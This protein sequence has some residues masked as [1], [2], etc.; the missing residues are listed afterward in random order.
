MASVIRQLFDLD[1]GRPNPRSKQAERQQAGG[2]GLPPYPDGDDQ[3]PE[4]YGTYARA[5]WDEQ[6][7]P[8]EPLHRTWIRNILMLLGFQ[9][10]EWDRVTG[11]F[12][13][14]PVPSYRERP[15]TNLMLP[16]FK[17]LL[18]K[19]TKNRPATQCVAASNEPK[20]QN[21]A[22]LGNDAL[23]GKWRELK[24]GKSLRRLLAWCIPTGTAYWYP[25]WNTETGNLVPLTLHVEAQKID[26]ETGQPVGAEVIE[27][28]CDENGEPK[29]TPD[30]RYDLE[31]Q[32]HYVD[33]GDV[34]T[35]VL[36][37]FQV[38]VNPGA[39]TEEDVSVVLV[40][41][42]LP[43]R[44]IRQRWP[45]LDNV[46]AED[47][48]I[49]EL[50]DS[51]TS[52]NITGHDP[53]NPQPGGAADRDSMLPKALVLR[54][55]E[56]QRPEYPEGRYWVTV[57]NQLAEKPG[58]LPNGWPVV[59][60]L[61]EVEI[62]G[63][64]HGG[65]T[66]E[67]AVQIQ[68][69]YN[70]VNGLIKEHHNLMLRGKWLV[71]I[72]SNIRR[73]Q[74]T[75]MAGEVI[76][77]TPG[78][79]PQMATLKPL[80]DRVYVERERLLQDFETITGIHRASMGQAPPGVSAG[81]AF[82]ILQEA[83]DTDLGP[84]LA[85]V[86]EAVAQ[87]GWHFIQ[88]MQRHYDTQRLVH[89]VGP[90]RHYQARAFQGSDLTGVVDVV[91]EAGSAFPWSQAARQNLLLE[92]VGTPAGMA[93][94]Q[95]PTTGGFDRRRFASLLPIAGLDSLYQ[96]EDVDYNEAQRVD[97]AYEA[98]DGRDVAELPRYMP[99]Q[100][101]MVHLEQVERTLKTATFREWAPA[102][103]TAYIAHWQELR[104]VVQQQMLDRMAA[105]SAGN[106]GAPGGP[107]APG[108]KPPQVQAG[109]PQASGGGE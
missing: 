109:P 31:A 29:L 50:F 88:M 102:A 37:P 100:N 38:R 76:Q 67:S 12:R 82:L 56:K 97:E 94:F 96:Y 40:G 51:L 14:P 10:W 15:V 8:L 48:G 7:G 70:E 77:H 33:E 45:D 66:F 85:A 98:W 19:T 6:E 108:G 26:E 84:F 64:W 53:R 32:P 43:I 71:P 47:A 89:I 4:K 69:E 86:E 35:K 30:Q 81:K 107:S 105:A 73:G 95:D 13:L 54:Y 93:I 74:I 83:D 17:N 28:P 49:M 3:A 80:P 62:T 9:W 87:L 65:S 52:G 21:S 91:A 42:V 11:T 78:L 72:G 36:S 5:L 63:R 57:G 90:D 55:H 92:L 39:E 20:D 59:I 27:V 1:D 58:P 23:K 103:Q 68:R 99:W 101:V 16:F 34:G 22:A 18:A 60:P 2:D 41:E 25:F 106:G 44:E 79:P 46:V 104:A 24:L 75:Q 61:K